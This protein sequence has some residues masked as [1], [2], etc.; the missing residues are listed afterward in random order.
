MTYM[1]PLPRA[2]FALALLLSPGSLDGKP[3]Y[4]Q[5]APMHPCRNA[6]Q[7]LP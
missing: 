5:R 7:T 1:R 4:N 6:W 3:M 2:E